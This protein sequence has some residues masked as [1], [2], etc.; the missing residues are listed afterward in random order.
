MAYEE[1]YP[2]DASSIDACVALTKHLDI[3][4]GPGG[5]R[6]LEIPAEYAAQYRELWHETGFAISRS[7]LWVAA[8]WPSA[9]IVGHKDAPLGGF[10]AARVTRYHLPIQT[11]NECW[12]LSGKAWRQLKKGWLYTLNPA[13]WHGSVNWGTE[14]RVHLVI[15]VREAALPSA[16]AAPGGR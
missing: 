9:Q 4:P 2:L 7:R 5:S 12:S 13:E 10:E 8:L 6:L 11:N 16:P 15:D 14:V 1:E 3:Q